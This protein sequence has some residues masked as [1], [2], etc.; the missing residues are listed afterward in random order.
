MLSIEKSLFPFI[1]VLLNTYFAVSIVRLN[2]C[3]KPLHLSIRYVIYKQSKKYVAS[4][5]PTIDSDEINFFHLALLS[6]HC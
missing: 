4:Y 6:T 5:I 2:G 3:V 1:Y